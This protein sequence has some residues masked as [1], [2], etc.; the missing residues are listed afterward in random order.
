MRDIIIALVA[1]ILWGA[2]IE[3]L[4]AVGWYPDRWIAGRVMTASRKAQRT[5][6]WGLVAILALGTLFLVNWI[7][8]AEHAAVDVPSVVNKMGDIHNEHGITTQGQKGD[9]TI[10]P[11]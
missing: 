4:H 7:F 1:A 3:V 2:G 6:F 10:S 5:A 8:P 9:N 11:K